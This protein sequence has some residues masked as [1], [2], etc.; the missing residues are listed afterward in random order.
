LRSHAN[1]RQRNHCSCP[2]C[3]QYEHAFTKFA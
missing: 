3:T 1:L 2:F